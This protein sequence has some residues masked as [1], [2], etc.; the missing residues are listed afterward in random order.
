[1]TE[2]LFSDKHVPFGDDAAI[3]KTFQE[4]GYVVVSNVLSSDQ[5]SDA[6]ED[7]WT[8]PRLLGQPGIDRNDPETWQGEWPQ[9]NGGKNFLGSSNVFLDA[10]SWDLMSHPRIIQLQKLLYQRDDIMYT[11]LGRWG[12]MRPT[13]SHPEWKTET[14]WLHWD[15]N[16]W[17]EPEFVRLQAIVCLTDNTQTSGGF[18]CVP[19][20]HKEFQ[21]WGEEHPLGTLFS[22]TGTMLNH[23]YGVGQPFPVP[24][25]D[26]SQERLVKVL[27]PAGSMVIWD[28]RLP[29]QN[30]PNTDSKALRIVF[31]CMMQVKEEKA[32]KERMEL[33]R[34]KIIVMETLGI[35]GERFP[36][37]LS[38]LGR[39][40]NCIPDPGTIPD[41]GSLPE[42]LKKAIPLVLEAGRAEGAGD[43]AQAIRCHQKALRLFPDIESWHKAIFN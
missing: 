29:H 26:P 41:L 11:S 30:F 4:D 14:N 2:Y 5:V 19:R 13:A 34:Q 1:M 33:M 39:E 28:S 10:A 36:H 16:P 8:S 25:D 3:V 6:L 17:T 20:F 31:Y 37:S 42:G 18:A 43:I 7:L 35:R 38:P 27:A 23:T 22:S 32:A 15:Q 24:A 40:V 21:R 12:V 9:S